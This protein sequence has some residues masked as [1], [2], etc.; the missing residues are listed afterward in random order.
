MQEN[1]L[2]HIADL[3]DYESIQPLEAKQM[4]EQLLADCRSA[5]TRHL[6]GEAAPG[7]NLVDDEIS[8]NDSLERYWGALS[9]LHAVADNDEL[10]AAYNDCLALLT[11]FSSW[12][13]QNTALQ[14]AYSR[15]RK[16]EAFALLS[17]EQ[18]RVVELELRDFH[19]AGVDLP[20]AEKAEYREIVLRLSDLGA[21]FAQNL[22]DSTEAWQ[23]HLETSERLSGLPESELAMLAGLA[24]ARDLDGWLIDLGFPAFNAVM[25]HAED[26]ALRHEVYLAYNTRASAKGPG[27]EA[28]D[29][30]PLMLEI[31][32]LR[33]RLARLL[34]FDQFVD[35]ALATRMAADRQ[36]V[37]SFVH[38]LAERA[39]PA[40]QAQ[41]DALSEFAASKGA[42]LPLQAWDIA[43]WSERLRHEELDLSDEMLKPYFPLDG[44][45]QGLQFVV[46]QLFGLR[47]V[48]DQSIPTWHEDARFYWLENSTGERFAGI[49]MDLYVRSGKRGG[50]WMD[51]CRS[52]RRR[53]EGV[54]MPIA[55]LVCN[56]PAPVEGQPSLL[57]HDEALT[58]LHE[59]GH[60]FHHLL[61]TVDW[62]QINGINNVEWDAVELPSQLFENWG[63]GDEFL[64]R[65]ARHFSTG[66]SLP[67]ELRKRMRRGRT[68]QKALVLVKQL[69]YA[70]VD[71]RLHSQF[72]PDAPPD[73]L[74]VLEGVRAEVAVVPV[75]PE[76]RFLN[77]FSHIFGGGYSA[78]YYSYLWAEELAADAWGRFCEAGVFNPEAG[79]QL[80][81]EILAVGASRPALES[82]MA[83]RGRAPDSGP[84]LESY[85]LEADNS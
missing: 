46:E 21:R 6:E 42:E 12:R 13:Q 62:P 52:R 26:R 48:H 53:P 54:Q 55:Q 36:E 1:T 79:A 83:F 63:W 7:W 24:R 57:T 44:M 81:K 59:A 85:G 70:L 67:D 64:A 25:T 2:K 50:A 4:V 37:E 71:L 51:V 60:C 56:F 78:G 27:G 80:R 18:Q 31:L 9:H 84:L 32:E 28:F 16:S 22:L 29:N 69:E 82:F 65:F 23:M 58:L 74:A 14:A 68:F 10:R 61:T 45:L 17:A 34:G 49:Y 38:E 35:Y 33:Y 19:L 72:D 76:N 47:L 3:P 39:R 30:A 15:L 73:P 66:E 8:S 5:I 40:A 41:L 43:F 75:P 11:E 20:E 77:G